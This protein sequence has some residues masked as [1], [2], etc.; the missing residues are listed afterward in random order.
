MKKFALDINYRCRAVV[1]AFSLFLGLIFVGLSSEAFAQDSKYEPAGVTRET[2]AFD[3]FTDE[4][5]RSHKFNIASP[6][7]KDIEETL[8]R[9]FLPGEPVRN[10][11]RF[12][13]KQIEKPGVK[14]MMLAILPR[15]LF[16][17]R[18]QKN[19]THHQCQY[20]FTIPHEIAHKYYQTESELSRINTEQSYIGMQHMIY[21]Y[22]IDL[23]LDEHKNIKNIRG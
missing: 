1:V 7:L 19:R 15:K 23:L 4:M 22:V 11:V 16:L 9:L 17:C 2:F 21:I 6:V 13:G 20:P 3:A 5:L 18:W 12:F 10:F 8:N 14:Q